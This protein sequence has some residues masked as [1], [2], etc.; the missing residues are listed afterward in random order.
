MRSDLSYHLISSEYDVGTY[1][2]YVLPR[3]LPNIP[4]IPF[5]FPFNLHFFCEKKI[6]L[7][8]EMIDNQNW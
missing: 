8:P 2:I 7:M 3:F 6:F 1:K 5:I 4:T